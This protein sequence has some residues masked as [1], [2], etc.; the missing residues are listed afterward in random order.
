MKRKMLLTHSKSVF[1]DPSVARHLS[2]LHSK[3][4][5]APTDKAPNNIVFVCK[6]QYIDCLIQ[7]LGID[8]SLDNPTYT[9]RRNP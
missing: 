8:S 2:K 1:K 6:S 7:E 4:V 5:V 9:Q 3:Y